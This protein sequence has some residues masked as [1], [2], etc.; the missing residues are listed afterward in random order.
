M[1]EYF[2]LKKKLHWYLW[3][4]NWFVSLLA[5]GIVSCRLPRYFYYE[6]R[7][8]GAVKNMA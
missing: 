5:E 7:N 2:R 6:C 8:G 1:K 4:E 3:D